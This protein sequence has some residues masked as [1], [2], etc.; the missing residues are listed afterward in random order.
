MK[1]LLSMILSAFAFSAFAQGNFSNLKQQK[2]DHL[3]QKIQMMNDSRTCIVGAADQKALE[4]CYS[5][6][7]A[8]KEELK[9]EH[10]IQ[11]E[12]FK[13]KAKSSSDESS[14]TVE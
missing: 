2:L 6:M 10:K 7:E 4:S 8:Q 12:E 1:F 11:K 5:D 9:E 14:D 3:D 13:E